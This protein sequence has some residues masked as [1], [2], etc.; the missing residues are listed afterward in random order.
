MDVK[1]RRE[2]PVEYR[3]VEEL[4]R[5]AFWNLY[6]PGCN[7]HFCLHIMR[8]HADF[9]PELDLVAEYAGK[10]VGNIV[11][12]RAGVIT[13]AGRIH[14]VICFG[15]VSVLPAYQKQGIGGALI[16]CSLDKARALGFAAVFIYGD[17]RYYYRFGFRCAEKFEIANSEGKFAFALMALELIPG[18][19]RN[20]SGRFIESASYQVDEEAFKK[21]E[22]TFPPKEKLATPS[23]AEFKIMAGLV[24]GKLA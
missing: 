16:R 22:S 24:Y 5:E 3:T 10:L 4:T 18:A 12:A 7:E 9:I 2:L 11:Y 20:I 8:G 14:N 19:L 13:G 17:P 15:P 21:Y 23:Q 6:V 1:I